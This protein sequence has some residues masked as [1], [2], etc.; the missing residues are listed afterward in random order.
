MLTKN[1]GLRSGYQVRRNDRLRQGLQ[2][3]GIRGPHVEFTATGIAFRQVTANLQGFVLP[4]G[5]RGIQ[6]D[7]FS[8][9]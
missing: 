2:A 1:P 4:Q 5:A 3:A 7:Q 9:F 8:D 6:R